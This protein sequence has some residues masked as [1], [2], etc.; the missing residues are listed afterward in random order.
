MAGQKVALGSRVR[1]GRYYT[2]QGV[3]YWDRIDA[4][5]IPVQSDD[6]YRIVQSYDSLDS[7]A[8]DAYG[9]ESLQWVIASANGIDLWP[10]QLR[11]G[12]T[13]RIPSPRYV[14]ERLFA[15]AMR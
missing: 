14:K 4:V 13:I 2:V 15:A 8:V 5:E 11:P 12:S 3:E 7:L 6:R 1:F 9:D 10:T